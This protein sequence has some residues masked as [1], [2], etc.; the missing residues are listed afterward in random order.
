MQDFV[1]DYCKCRVLVLGCG[2]ILL[3][4]DGIGPAVIEYL[5]KNYKIPED[6]C[7]I[8]ART[9]VREIL[10]MISLSEIKPK[11][12]VLV[13]SIDVGRKAGEVLEIDIDSIPLNKL[14]NFSMHQAPTSNLLKELKEF[15]RIEIKILAVQVKEFPEE[16]RMGISEEV[17]SCIP[18]ISQKIMEEISL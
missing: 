6:V 4:D 13:D 3:G 8:D 10:F 16:V 17:L 5:Q 2:N 18:E 7:L 14:D 15:C 11:K 12:I 9:S 1:P